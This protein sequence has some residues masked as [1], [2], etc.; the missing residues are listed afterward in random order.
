MQAET[1]AA[2]ALAAAG[3]EA[4]AEAAAAA[5]EAAGAEL[6]AL[7]KAKDASEAARGE[8]ALKVAQAAG[9]LRASEELKEA[10]YALNLIL[11][12]RHA[13]L[14]ISNEGLQGNTLENKLNLRNPL[15]V[16]PHQ[17]EYGPGVSLRGE[18]PRVI[19]H[20]PCRACTSGS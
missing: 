18:T 19:S 15:E 17:L 3:A 14:V 5:A 10:K 9:A 7:Q 4:A 16:S 11:K 12:S 13:A 1:Q 6:A 2:K 20:R 8:L